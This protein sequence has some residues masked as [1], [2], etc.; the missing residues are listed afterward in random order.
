MRFFA[1]FFRTPDLQVG[2]IY[3]NWMT[4]GHVFSI[5]MIAVAGILSYQLKTK[6]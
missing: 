4:I 3:G 6:N 5:F 2:Y 1:E